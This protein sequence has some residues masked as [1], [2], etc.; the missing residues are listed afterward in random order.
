MTRQRFLFPGEALFLHASELVPG[1]MIYI[2]R[3]AAA[4]TKALV[5]SVLPILPRNNFST[6]ITI[7]GV[8]GI[9][10]FDAL[11]STTYRIAAFVDAPATTRD[12]SA[13]LGSP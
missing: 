9:E 4:T 13:L 8:N 11:V 2:S 6:T 3:F 7:L 5:V 10:V 12:R 1:D